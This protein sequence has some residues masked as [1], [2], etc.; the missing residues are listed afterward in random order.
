MRKI[1]TVS[2]WESGQ[3]VYDTGRLGLETKCL[4]NRLIYLGSGIRLF[5]SPDSQTLPNVK[6]IKGL[7][8]KL[9]LI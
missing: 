3:N 5:D 7:Y 2:S 9:Y 4:R 6:H 1:R 8:I